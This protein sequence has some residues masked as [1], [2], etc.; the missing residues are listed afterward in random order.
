MGPLSY[1]RVLL[2]LKPV[3]TDSFLTLI[4]PTVLRLAKRDANSTP[5]TGLFGIK[6]V[7]AGGNTPDRVACVITGTSAGLPHGEETG[8]VFSPSNLQG[9]AE[10]TM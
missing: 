4:P 1:C 9:L 6:A 2:K 8:D 10:G 7:S 3:L 5:A